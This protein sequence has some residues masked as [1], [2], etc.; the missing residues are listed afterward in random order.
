MSVKINDKLPQFRRNLYAVMDD[1][2]KEGSGDL[3]RKAK[4]RAPFKAGQLRGETEAK[5]V[6]PLKWRTS[7]WKEYA[8]FQEFGGDS[9]HRVR[10]YSYA[11]TGK[12]YLKSS[13]DE[14]AQRLKLQFIKHAKRARV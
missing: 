2:L 1:A 6:S 9:S 3:L 4:Q 11:G 12:R 7:F 14:V 13:G 8:R 5:R 10:N